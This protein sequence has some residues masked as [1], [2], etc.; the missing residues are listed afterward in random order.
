MNSL[1]GQ[2]KLDRRDDAAMW[3]QVET[4]YEIL[5]KLGQGSY[6][7][8]VKARHRATGKIVSIKL[9]QNI[10]KSCDHIKKLI[11]EI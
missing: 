2:S 4:H 6:G 9:I 8:V 1:Q 3:T 11:S 10:Y 5:S 7:K